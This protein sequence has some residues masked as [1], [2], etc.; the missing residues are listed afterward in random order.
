MI[1]ENIYAA[2]RKR[3]IYSAIFMDIAGAFNNAHH[4]RLI[5]NLRKRLIP[6]PI[7]KWINSFLEERFTQLRFNGVTSRSI[8][9]PAGVP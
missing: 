2:W 7:A 6:T 9:T 4:D 1:L 3:E 8:P 5:H